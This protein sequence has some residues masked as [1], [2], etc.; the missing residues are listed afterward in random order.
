M[1]RQRD[2]SSE[3][4]VR[5]DKWLWAA[6]FYKTRALATEAI[7]GGHVHLNGSRPKPSR[8]LSVGD[9]LEIRKG[10]VQFVVEVEGLSGRRGPASEAV[11]LYR[12]SEESIAAREAYAEE[13]RLLRA[14]QPKPDRRP[15]KRG[16]RH[17]IR[18][19]N[20]YGDS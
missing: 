10:S 5:L 7:H 17:I 16:R 12:E 1:A 2:T 8:T 4:K 18:F 14:S 3:E 11:K 9:R 20:K 15:D 19:I 6:R 13:R